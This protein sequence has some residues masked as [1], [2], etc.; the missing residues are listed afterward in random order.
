MSLILIGR[1]AAKIS[2]ETRADDALSTHMQPCSS[3]LIL[4]KA[5]SIPLLA[6]IRVVV[7]VVIILKL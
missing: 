5:D 1:S 7:C 4:T 3:H 6:E 2:W